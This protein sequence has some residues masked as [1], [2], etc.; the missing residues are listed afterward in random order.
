[1]SA[2]FYVSSSKGSD[3]NSGTIPSLPWRSLSRAFSASLTPGDAILLRQGDT[4]TL[5]LPFNVSGVLGSGDAPIVLSAYVDATSSVNRPVIARST[6]GEQTGILFNF[7]NSGGLSVMGIEFI[8]AEVGLGFTFDASSNPPPA[9]GYN[10]YTIE[11]C[12]FHSQKGAFYNASTGSWWGSAIA[13]AREGTTGV[14]ASSVR[15]A[16]CLFTGCDQAYTNNLPQPTFPSQSWTRTFINGLDV[17][18]S[19]CNGRATVVG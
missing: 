10:N 13:F 2:P 14:T 5:T 15:V 1:M 8:G 3:S 7:H 4:W 17:S 16:H 6:Q 12:F 9:L 18:T 11:D 19:S